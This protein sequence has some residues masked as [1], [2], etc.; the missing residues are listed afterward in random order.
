MNNLNMAFIG[1]RWTICLERKLSPFFWQIFMPTSFMVALS[2]IG[3]LVPPNCYPGRISLLVTIVL[4]IISVMTSTMH[5]SPK[6]TG[7]T[8]I[9]CWFL[10]CL[11]QVAIASLEYAI[12]IYFM[13]FSKQNQSLPK[14]RVSKMPK[15]T[16]IKEITCVWGSRVDL[17]DHFSLLVIPSSFILMIIVYFSV[18]LSSSSCND[19][20][21]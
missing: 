20:L 8:A 14:E 1:F 13:R 18:Y 17:I 12:I 3:F 11:V 21:I 10:I 16:N 5:E 7:L 15:K 19:L 4:C 2:W 6:G 9:N